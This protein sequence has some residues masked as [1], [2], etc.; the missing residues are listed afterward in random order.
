MPEGATLALR[1]W[2]ALS[3][4]GTRAL[5]VGLGISVEPVG[6]DDGEPAPP[7]APL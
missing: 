3:P 4:A 1:S 6:D 2:A 5:T 7:V